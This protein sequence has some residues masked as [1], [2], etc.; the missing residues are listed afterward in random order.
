MRLSVC[1]L[2]LALTALLGFAIALLLGC[3]FAF[4][5]LLL[6]L[7]TQGI[8]L[9]LLLP[10]VLVTLAL[11]A[12]T[13]TFALQAVAFGPGALFVIA[14]IAVIAIAGLLLIDDATT[15]G[16]GVVISAVARVVA[17]VA[18][19]A[20]ATVVRDTGAKHGGGANYDCNAQ[21]G[22]QKAGT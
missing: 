15:T 17:A 21:A 22:S 12:V 1:I 19:I 5:P 10:A 4:L 8:V 20:T 14:V 13:L 18:V 3:A 6:L 7:L 9:T 2:L 11:V 16:V